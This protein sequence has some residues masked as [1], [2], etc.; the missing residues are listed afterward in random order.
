MNNI[1]D[2]MQS[3]EAFIDRI[4]KELPE[5]DIVLKAHLSWNPILLPHPFF[6]DVTRFVIGKAEHA[7]D[8]ASLVPLLN[9]LDEG[10]RVG[11]QAVQELIG[12]S[13]VEN[14]IAEDDTLRAL[15]PLMRPKLQELV[16]TCCGEAWMKR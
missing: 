10:L 3:P 13:F 2:A 16:R 11:S 8:R 6:G 15:W 9:S 12:A 5:L 14:L 1:N 7:E 4:V